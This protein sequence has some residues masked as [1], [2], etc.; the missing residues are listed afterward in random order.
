MKKIIDFFLN[1]Y[2]R[3][4]V[5][6]KNFLDGNSNIIRHRNNYKKLQN[7]NDVEYKIFSQ[8]GEDGIIDYLLHSLKIEKPKFI[9]IG[10]GDYI[11]SNTRFIYERTSP[12]GL[13]IDCLSDLK[14]KVSKNINLWKGNLQIVEKNIN[15]ENL[16]TTL[17][18]ENFFNDIDIFSLDIDGIDYWILN[19]LPKNFSKI[20]ILEY[21]PTFGSE[22]NVTV[23]NIVDF[24]RTKYHYSNLCFGMS[25]KAAIKLMNEKNYYF[26]GTCLMRNN[27]FFVSKNFSKDDYFENLI[28]DDI[29]K[30]TDSNFRESRDKQGKLNYLSGNNKIL[31]IQD[32]KVIDLNSKSSAPIK[33]KDLLNKKDR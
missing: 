27:A 12:K 24:D 33:I 9:E 14:N 28:I 5:Q 26:L 20:I 13:I 10:V 17:K 22:L 3:K 32:C 18:S 6:K 25:L 4:Y 30:S 1:K 11:E 31:E 19:E 7:L 21:N 23:P 2:F 29:Y 15:S 16:I 8:S